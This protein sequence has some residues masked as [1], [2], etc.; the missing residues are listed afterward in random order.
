VFIMQALSVRKLKAREKNKR[1]KK[2]KEIPV[3]PRRDPES[4]KDVEAYR[5]QDDQHIKSLKL[6][7]IGT[8]RLYPQEIFLV[9]ICFRLQG[10]S[11]AVRVLSIKNSNGTIGY[12]NRDSP[13]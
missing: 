13:V 5:F 8:G 7:A 10:H 11:A 4:F 12:R 3:R 9:L 6:S 1:K 2:G